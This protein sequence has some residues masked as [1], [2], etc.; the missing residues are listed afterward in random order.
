MAQ[1][2][3]VVEDETK[4][5]SLLQG[6]L[7]RAGF[8][9]LTTGSGAEAL[10]LAASAGPDLI[11]LD[12]GLPD[13]PGETV[14][15]E[16]RRTSRTPILILTA[17]AG[18]EDRIAG[19]ELGAD[20]YVTKPFSPQEVVLRVQAILRRAAEAAAPGTAVRS[21]GDGELE[22][23]EDRH[24]ARVRGQLVD[25]TPSEWSLLVALA[26]APG[27][28]YSRTELINRTRGYEFASER[29]IDSHVKNLRRKIELD[30]HEPRIVETVLGTGY[31]LGLRRDG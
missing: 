26:G 15:R 31:R 11:L 17:K 27:R 10:T 24:E 7:E 4:I 12:L 20:D 8:S 6:Y 9:V 18:E 28:V 30:P 3:L 21:F 5:R 1:T 23:D 22:L 13:V 19:L 14:A 25:L 29:A 16:V 2:I